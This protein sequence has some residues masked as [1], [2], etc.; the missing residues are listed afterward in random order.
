MSEEVVAQEVLEVLE[1]LEALEAGANP[2][3]LPLLAVDPPPNQYHAENMMKSLPAVVVDLPL[4]QCSAELV[5]LVVAVVPNRAQFLDRARFLVQIRILGHLLPVFYHAHL[6][7]P[8]WMAG[9][10]ET[11]L[12]LLWNP[13]LLDRLPPLPSNPSST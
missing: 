5:A 13:S 3:N 8:S 11:N 7:V 2:N 9:F 6:L 4:N 10:S 12:A 1:A